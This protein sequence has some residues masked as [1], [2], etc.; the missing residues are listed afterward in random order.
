MKISGWLRT[1]IWSLKLG[2]ISHVGIINEAHVFFQRRAHSM[3]GALTCHQ[4]RMFTI[5]CQWLFYVLS[6]CNTKEMSVTSFDLRGTVANLGHCKSQAGCKVRTEGQARRRQRH[7]DGQQNPT[8]VP[9]SRAF[10]LDRGPLLLGFELEIVD[11]LLP[12]A[13]QRFEYLRYGKSQ[14]FRL[15]DYGWVSTFLIV[16][17]GMLVRRVELNAAGF[18]GCQYCMFYLLIFCHGGLFYVESIC[19]MGKV[20]HFLW[21][22]RNS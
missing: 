12:S 2:V 8:P 14:T 6:V 19:N 21:A 9:P 17:P 22:T 11:L 15:K 13:P 10:R 18:T 4:Y 16:L 5:S 20:S 1:Q 7:S 3:S